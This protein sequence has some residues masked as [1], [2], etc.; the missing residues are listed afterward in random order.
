MTAPRKEVRKTERFHQIPIF[1][2]LAGK[3]VG[4]ILRITKEQHYKPGDT[5]FKPGEACDGFYIILD[6][7]VDIRLSNDS[8]KTQ[9]KIATLSHRSVFGEMSFLGKRPRSAWAVAVE[10]TRLNRVDGEAFQASLDRG[11]VSAYKV[12]HNFA[13]LIAGRLRRVEDELLDVL[14]NIGPEKRKEKLAELQEFRH[15]LYRDWSF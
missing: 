2:N 5:I 3:E 8:G 13:I 14:Q 10:D 6:G 15:T 7:R 11:D 9:T 12:I 1:S 4:E